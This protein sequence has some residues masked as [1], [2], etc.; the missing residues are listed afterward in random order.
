MPTL[1]TFHAKERNIYSGQSFQLC[2]DFSGV[3]WKDKSKENQKNEND[4]KKNKRTIMV[5]M[6]ND[7]CNFS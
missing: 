1:F 4:Q 5:D 3:V 7:R 2:L 6:R